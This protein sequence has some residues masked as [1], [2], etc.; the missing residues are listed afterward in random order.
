MTSR[1]CFRRLHGLQQPIERDRFVVGVAV[2]L[3][4]GIGRDQVIRALDLD[5][6]AGEIDDG[7][8]GIAR[9]V[10]EVAQDAPH[11]DDA[12]ITTRI[13]D[14]EL[15]VL[16][17]FGDRGRIARRIIEARDVLIGGIADHKRDALVGIGR[18]GDQC[19]QNRQGCDQPAHDPFPLSD[20]GAAY[21]QRRRG[22]QRGRDQKAVLLC[23]LWRASLP[24]WVGFRE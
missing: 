11:F 18:P 20:A 21:T 19:R 8:V 17:K 4:H 2:A 1:N 14:V 23:S 24:P 5:P 13:D 7:H 6:V 10:E 9:L 3:Q 16:Q 12:E 22:S 15:C